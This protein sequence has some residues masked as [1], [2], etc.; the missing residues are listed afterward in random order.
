MNELT[1]CK[2]GVNANIEDIIISGLI[3]N[4]PK[5][6]VI[7]EKKYCTNKEFIDTIINV[8]GDRV[9]FEDE[10]KNVIH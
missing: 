10:F 7:H 1:E 5:K 3:T 8:F 4:A 2:V 9:K 6:I